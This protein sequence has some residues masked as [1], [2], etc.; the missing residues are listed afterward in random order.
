MDPFQ[1]LHEAINRIVMIPEPE[2]Q[3]F[4]QNLLLHKYNKGEF[5]CREGQTE[6]HIFYLLK[7][8]TRNFFR[9]DGKEF[10]VDFHFEGE[11]VT[12]YHSFLTRK[13]SFIN[14]EVIEPV[15]ACLIP[16]DHLYH[17][18]EISKHGERVG[19]LL[20]EKHY[21]RRLE[22][23]TELLS[24]SA[25]ERYAQLMQRNPALVQHISVKHLSSY[26]GIQPE[27]LSRIRRQYIRN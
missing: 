22:R 16:H 23:E 24:L 21:I 5:L 27:S 1:Q 12:A 19:R 26:L 20:A 10:T 13:P 2:W 18:Y 14:L 11:M 7:G 15:E 9:R 3:Q 6:N 17:F 25:E 4:S 8:A